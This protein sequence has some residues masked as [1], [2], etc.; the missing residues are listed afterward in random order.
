MASLRSHGQSL[1]ELHSLLVE[2]LPRGTNAALQRLVAQQD[3]NL[4]K[5]RCFAQASDRDRQAQRVPDPKAQDLESLSRGEG[6]GVMGG[7]GSVRGSQGGVHPRGFF[8]SSRRIFRRIFLADFSF[9]F[10]DQKKS[11]ANPPL[12]GEFLFQKSPGLEAPE[13]TG[14]PPPPPGESKSNS[15]AFGSGTERFSGWEFPGKTPG[16]IGPRSLRILI[17]RIAVGWPCMECHV[18]CHI[19]I[20]WV[21]D[22]VKQSEGWGKNPALIERSPTRHSKFFIEKFHHKSSL[23]VWLPKGG[24]TI[25]IFCI[26]RVFAW[27]GPS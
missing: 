9:V 13:F 5:Q 21:W 19:S 10:C 27:G 3:V 18:P 4:H 12:R 11:T 1:R 17:G 20:Y 15:C 24:E 23:L 25:R 6:G 7:G 14:L 26:F 8:D 22:S 16:L 2:H